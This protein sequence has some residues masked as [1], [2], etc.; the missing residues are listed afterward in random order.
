MTRVIIVFLWCLVFL[1]V[2]SNLTNKPIRSL[3]KNVYMQSN[4]DR[5]VLTT[6][7]IPIDR[8]SRIATQNYF[9]FT[10]GR[11]PHQPTEGYVNFSERQAYPTPITPSTST[12]CYA[13]FVV[14]LLVAVGIA[15]GIS[16]PL[17]ANPSEIPNFDPNSIVV[18][19]LPQRIPE[20]LVRNNFRNI[21]DDGC[22]KTSVLFDDGNCYPLLRPCENPLFWTTVDPLTKR[23]CY[24]SHMC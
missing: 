10:L 24:H 18:T 14:P 23:V 9:N 1:L 13:C 15:V 2:P 8:V 19:S 17:S 12:N 20:N 11:R 4:F 5:K 3:E 22:N 6:R 21:S 16:V 7:P